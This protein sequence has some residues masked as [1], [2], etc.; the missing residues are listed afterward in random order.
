MP[1]KR[2]LTL[3]VLLLSLVVAAS[4]Q[5]KKPFT[6][7]ASLDLQVLTFPPTGV[8]SDGTWI[9]YA[10]TDGYQERSGTP[11]DWV[12]YAAKTHV[13]VSSLVAPESLQ[14]T[15]G[16]TFSWGPAW[17]PDGKKLAMYVCFAQEMPRAVRNYL[18][19]GHRHSA[20]L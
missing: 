15:A 18:R 16:D 10:V 8:S 11:L 4:A 5:E 1:T 6:P 20:L 13:W 12:G 3:L 17:S 9:A 2:L 14:V 7:E 19:G